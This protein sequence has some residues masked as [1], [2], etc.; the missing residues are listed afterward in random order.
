MAS[1]EVRAVVEI[2]GEGLMASGPLA[3]VSGSTQVFAQQT[4]IAADNTTANPI[5]IC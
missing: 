2:A 5:A 1:Q 3:D 4:T